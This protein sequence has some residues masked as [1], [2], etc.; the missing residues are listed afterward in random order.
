MNFC[1]RVVAA[2]GLAFLAGPVLFAA[3]IVHQAPSEFLE[4]QLPD[5]SLIHISEPTRLC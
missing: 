2:Y 1:L 4:Q 3:E 5:L